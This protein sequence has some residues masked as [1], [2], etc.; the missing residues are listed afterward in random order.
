MEE[1]IV[2]T[3]SEE[4]NDLDDVNTPRTI[5]ELEER[6]IL[7][8]DKDKEKFHEQALIQ[9]VLSNAGVNIYEEQ[10]KEYC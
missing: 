7:E 1:I 8:A 4:L 5:G 6:E 3:L 10:Y 2:T 9:R